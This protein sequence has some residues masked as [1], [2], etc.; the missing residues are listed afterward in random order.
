MPGIILEVLA[1]RL[2][3]V[4]KEIARLA[5]PP[6]PKDWRRVVGLFDG[7]EF[8]KQVLAEGKSIRQADREAALRE[9]PEGQ[10]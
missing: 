8:M 9:S 5:G 3:A 4:E 7:S 6:C 1:Q 10:P 2:E